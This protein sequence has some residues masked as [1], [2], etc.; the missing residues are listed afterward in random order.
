MGDDFSILEGLLRFTNRRHGLIATNIANADT[1]D[2]RIRDLRFEQALEGASLALKATNHAHMGGGGPMVA[3]DMVIEESEPWADGNNVEL[4]ME[5]AK[6][7]EN[8]LLH[9]A[10]VTMLTTKIRMFKNAL[11]RQ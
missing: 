4:D 11:R 5:V 7:T 10:G 9:Q 6:M 2:H 1:P 8:A 3:T